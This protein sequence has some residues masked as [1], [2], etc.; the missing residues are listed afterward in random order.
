MTIKAQI[1]EADVMKVE[2]GQKVYFT[3]LGDSEKK[4]YAT[5]RQV[6]PA[7]ESIN[8]ETQAILHHHQVLRFIIMPYLMYQM[9]MANCVLI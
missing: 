9:M 5:L 6:E 3:T 1:S 8:T 2:E 4:R 7:P